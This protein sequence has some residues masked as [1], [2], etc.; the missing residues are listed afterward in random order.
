MSMSKTSAPAK[1]ACAPFGITPEAIVETAK[2]RLQVRADQTRLSR[3][4]HPA[5][6]S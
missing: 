4:Q 3:P 6:Q 1:N 5:P 2:A